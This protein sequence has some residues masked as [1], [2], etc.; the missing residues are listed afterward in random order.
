MNN[1][2]ALTPEQV[3]EALQVNQA[4][5]YQMIKR[6]ELLAKKIGKKLYRISPVWLSW[7]TEGLDFDVI[8]MEKEDSKKLSQINNLLK[9][10][11]SE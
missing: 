5:V 4:M 10:V 8:K 9:Q 2:Q 11:R 7:L 1:I 3:A 6:G